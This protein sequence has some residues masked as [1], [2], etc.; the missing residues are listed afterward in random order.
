LIYYPYSEHRLNR[1]VLWSDDDQGI[2]PD[3]I[4]VETDNLASGINL[5]EEALIWEHCHGDVFIDQNN[6]PLSIDPN[7]VLHRQDLG[8]LYFRSII[9]QDRSIQFIA[10]WLEIYKIQKGQIIEAICPDLESGPN[11]SGHSQGLDDD[12]YLIPSWQPVIASG[13]TGAGSMGSTINDVDADF[14][15]LVS[16]GDAINI[17]GAVHS[18]TAVNSTQLTVNPIAIAGNDAPVPVGGRYVVLDLTLDNDVFLAAWDAD[19]D[20]YGATSVIPVIA[21]D[22][23]KG[24]MVRYEVPVSVTP[25]GLGVAIA[26]RK[27]TPNLF[28]VASIIPITGRADI[29]GAGTSGFEVTATRWSSKLYD[30]SGLRLVS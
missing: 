12:G 25:L 2:L 18:I 27:G 14:S 30:Y 9:Y 28:R 7:G 1:L 21:T 11:F 8:R 16:I 29:G 22:P 15:Q 24:P 3:G 6:Q 19:T 13:V 10:S 20:V 5:L 4:V 23:I 17:E 26:L